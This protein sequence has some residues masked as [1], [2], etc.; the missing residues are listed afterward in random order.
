MLIGKLAILAVG[1]IPAKRSVD[2][3]QSQE[4]RDAKCLSVVRQRHVEPIAYRAHRFDIGLELLEWHMLQDFTA[5]DEIEAPALQV[6]RN[7]RQWSADIRLQRRI[8]IS[9]DDFKPCAPQEGRN[10]TV[11][12]SN[13]QN[14]PWVERVNVMDLLHHGKQLRF[15]KITGVEVLFPRD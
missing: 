10:K 12:G 15:G 6:L 4:T 1:K 5:N 11:P 2:A 13:F 8:D 3:G 9:G 14:A 7:F